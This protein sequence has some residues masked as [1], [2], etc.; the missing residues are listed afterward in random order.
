MAL[1]AGEIGSEGDGQGSSQHGLT[2]PGHVFDEEVGA[3]EHGDHRCSHRTGC[4]EEDLREAVMEIAGE[5]GG[6]VEVGWTA[7]GLVASQSKETRGDVCCL[8]IGPLDVDAAG[9]GFSCIV[10]AYGARS[11]LVTAV[12]RRYSGGAGPSRSPVAGTHRMR[13]SVGVT[14]A[15]SQW[16]DTRAHGY[17]PV[18]D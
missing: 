2:D 15:L 17:P 16:R 3:G 1:H 7:G 5:R 4:T 6:I 14:P 11:A 12:V 10:E 8:T 18:G 13:T 9:H